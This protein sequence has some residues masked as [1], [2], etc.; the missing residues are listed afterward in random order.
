MTS[1]TAPTT[2]GLPL[3]GL[4]GSNPLG[5][6]AALG[7]LRLLG[8]S[9]RMKWVP[10]GGT[11]VPLVSSLDGQLLKEH[12]FLDDMQ[13][14]LVDDISK[15][16]AHV[17]TL[18]R[19]DSGNVRHQVFVEQHAQ[20]TCADRILADWLCALASDFGSVNAINQLQTTRRDYF[21]GNL[22][23]VIKSTT[24]DHL[25]RAILSPWDYA[26]PLEKQSLH[27]DPSE[28]RR[29]AHQWNQP[30]GDPNRKNSGGMLGANRLAIEAIPLFGSVPED[31]GLHTIGFT[32]N[33]STNTRWTWPIWNVNVSLQVVQSLLAMPLLQ[34]DKL[35]PKQRDKLHNTGIV[36][37]FRAS[38]ILV[39]KT[40]NFTPARRIA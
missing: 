5:F 24:V 3:P 13:A 28:D 40:P 14:R 17:L 19:N 1:H 10:S 2:E 15:H 26:D 35:T 21:L 39:G 11:W 22:T 34:I 16:P 9:I 23:E 33:R 8:S 31:D 7:T 20:A 4:D 36:A 32:G 27:L 29:H 25:R 37:A 38:R 6:L 18:L 30:S 12:S